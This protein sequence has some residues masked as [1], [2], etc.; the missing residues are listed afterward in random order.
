MTFLASVTFENV[1]SVELNTIESKEVSIVGME[2][3]LSGVTAKEIEIES[4]AGKSI[5]SRRA[6]TLGSLSSA[7]AATVQYSTNVTYKFSVI[8][9]SLGYDVTS[10]SSAYHQITDEITSSVING[11]LQ[12]NLKA[13]GVIA[14]VN[15]FSSLTITSLPHYTSPVLTTIET[16]SP[17][18]LPTSISQRNSGGGGNNG[19]HVPTPVFYVLGGVGGLALIF[20][21]LLMTLKGKQRQKKRGTER[22]SEIE[23]RGSEKNPMGF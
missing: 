2:M 16:A 8:L 19:G 20:L 11:N 3:S 21:G 10:A 6:L 14:G 15:T 23:T 13:A 12:Q 18:S 4:I 7:I 9:E 17:S 1:D 5:S 22:V